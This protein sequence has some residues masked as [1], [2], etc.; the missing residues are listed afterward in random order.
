[1]GKEQA[2]GSIGKMLGGALK[3][4]T[5]TSAKD[6]GYIGSAVKGAA[7]WGAVSGVS[8][9]AQGGSFVDGFKGGAVS[10]AMMGAGYKAAK[11]GA[12]GASH[13]GH[14]VGSSIGSYADMY[15]GGAGFTGKPGGV[16]VGA[17]IARNQ[18]SKVRHNVKNRQATNQFKYNRVKDQQ[19]KIL[20]LKNLAG[21]QN[22]SVNATGST[23]RP[24]T[25]ANDIRKTIPN[26][27]SIG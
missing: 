3:N 2:V 22:K 17:N 5:S 1:M 6:A 21:L 13:K 12:H 14:S 23:I 26:R 25:K 16:G 10:G 19:P 20:H 11:V 4:I 27:G 8:E 9:W 18:A 15:K 7:G 24:M